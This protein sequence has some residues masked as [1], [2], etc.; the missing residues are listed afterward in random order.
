LRN[1][2][3]Q[4]GAPY[5]LEVDCV[6]TLS[7]LNLGTRD[8]AKNTDGK[9]GSWEGVSVDE[10]VGDVEEPAEGANLIY[11]KEKAYGLVLKCLM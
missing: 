8:R 1:L 6:C 11:V 3:V 10:M 9:S 4:P 2:I 5:F 7:D